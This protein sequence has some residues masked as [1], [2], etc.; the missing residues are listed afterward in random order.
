MDPL[1]AKERSALMA[2][3]KSKGNRSTELKVLSVLQDRGIL[4]WTQH[5]PGIPGRPDFYFEE[6]RIA[7][8]VD[9]CFWHGCPRCGRIP[10]SREEFWASKIE[11]NRQRDLDT[12]RLLRERGYR[13]IRIW[14]HALKDEDW[15]LRLVRLLDEDVVGE[16][17]DNTPEESS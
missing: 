5:P 8:F 2:K 15:I 16:K 3:V 10:K 17:V 4:G 12:T 9:G 13:V 6:A 14:E 11:G 7:V 1:T